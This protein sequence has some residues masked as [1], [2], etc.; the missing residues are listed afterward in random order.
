MGTKTATSFSLPFDFSLLDTKMKLAAAAVFLAATAGLAAAQSDVGELPGGEVTPS[1]TV[2]GAGGSDTECLCNDDQYI[3]SLQSCGAS[4]CDSQED[5]DSAQSAAESLCQQ[6]GV[7]L[8]LSS[9]EP[10]SPVILRPQLT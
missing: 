7:T 1:D 4:N 8:S 2:G 6:A 3:D 5:I 10:S 9:I